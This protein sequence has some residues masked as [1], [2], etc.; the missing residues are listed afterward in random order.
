MKL[1]FLCFIFLLLLSISWSIHIMFFIFDF[2]DDVMKK[3]YVFNDFENAQVSMSSSSLNE[4]YNN[5]QNLKKTINE[6]IKNYDYVVNF[7][8]SN[9]NKKNIKNTIYFCCNKNQ[10]VKLNKNIEQRNVKFK[11]TKCFWQIIIKLIDNKWILTRINRTKHNHEKNDEFFH[12]I[13]RRYKKTSKIKTF[14]KNQVEQN[15]SFKNILKTFEKNYDNENFNKFTFKTFDVWNELNVMQEKKLNN[16][17]FIQI[18]NVK[19][20]NNSK[21]WMRVMLNSITSKIKFLFWINDFFMIMLKIN[22]EICIFDCIYKT[23]RHNMSLIILIEIIEMNT[24]FH[25][26]ICFMKKKN[27]F[28]LRT[29]IRFH[30]RVV[31]TFKHIFFV[32]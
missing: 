20:H 10:I 9:I 27:D 32:V 2:V 3:H 1:L 23:N 17:I 12:F 6:F 21:Y 8:N 16:I 13:L 29:I 7:R 22:D 5:F 25:S 30:Q 28:R 18:L 19:F 26:N 31:S 14:I 24:F 15:N 11:R 4:K